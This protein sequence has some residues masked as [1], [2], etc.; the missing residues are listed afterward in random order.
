MTGAH[1]S[2]VKKGPA[3]L[4]LTGPHE[5]KQWQVNQGELRLNGSTTA[6]VT[7]ASQAELSGT[8]SITGGLTTSGKLTAGLHVKGAF[9][10]LPTGEFVTAATPLTAS[11]QVNVQGRLTVGAERPPRLPVIDNQG[12]AKTTG[13]FTDLPEGA[14]VPGTPYR[15]TYKGG[16][17]ND[18]VL[19]DTTKA[20]FESEQARSA[21]ASSNHPREHALIATFATAVGLTNTVIAT[22]FWRSRRRRGRFIRV[23]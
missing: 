2:F 7:V 13:T 12:S 22:L 23:R 1:A 6:G 5:G 20:A 14:K 10:Q 8:G 3:T 19:A 21:S 4:T 9:D 17:G 16:D 15:I 18:V 11:G